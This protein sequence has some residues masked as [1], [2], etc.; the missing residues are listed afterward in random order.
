MSLKCLLLG[1]SLG[2]IYCRVIGSIRYVL[3]RF[4]E[5]IQTSDRPL[6]SQNHTELYLLFWDQLFCGGGGGGQTA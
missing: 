5:A 3:L 2:S 1:D 4:A 6:A